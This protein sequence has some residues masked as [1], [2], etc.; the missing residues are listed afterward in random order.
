MCKRCILCVMSADHQLIQVAFVVE[1]SNTTLKN[2]EMRFVEYYADFLWELN[3][4]LWVK[5]TLSLR[6]TSHGNRECH[7]VLAESTSSRLICRLCSC[8][9]RRYG[10]VYRIIL[11]TTGL[12]TICRVLSSWDLLRLSLRRNYYNDYRN[13]YIN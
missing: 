1:I 3:T 10:F 5:L 12:E 6:S 13:Y 4:S 11:H 2:A 8:I 9:W 7:Y